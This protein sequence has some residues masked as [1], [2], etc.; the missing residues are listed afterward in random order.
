[1]D[2]NTPLY[3]LPYEELMSLCRDTISKYVVIDPYR[4]PAPTLERIRLKFIEIY[5]ALNSHS[6]AL[7]MQR[8]SSERGREILLSEIILG[9]QRRDEKYKDL[10]PEETWVKTT[11]I[12]DSLART[13]ALTAPDYKEFI[14]LRGALIGKHQ[15]HQNQIELLQGIFHA[16]S[17]QTPKRNN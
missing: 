1:M 17:N 13:C 3:K 15:E 7:R 5:D 14:E 6:K 10:V 9:V 11:K 4:T 2:N 12:A 16:I 8:E